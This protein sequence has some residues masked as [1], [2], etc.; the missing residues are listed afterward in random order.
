M[1]DHVSPKVEPISPQNVVTD[2]EIMRKEI[3]ELNKVTCGEIVCDLN[4]TWQS[5]E[6]LPSY[7]IRYAAG[8]FLRD[9][10]GSGDGGTMQEDFDNTFVEIMASIHSHL[11]RFIAL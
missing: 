9:L 10:C 3:G 8:I 4:S 7:N 5:A 2:D 11:C 6:S 1:R